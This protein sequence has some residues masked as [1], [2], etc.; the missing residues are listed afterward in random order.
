MLSDLRFA[1]RQFLK[2]P[3]F[4]VI[5]VLTLAL[6]IG[7]NVAIFSAIDAVLLHP[8][9]YPDPDR[10]V[11]VGE[12]LKHFNLSKIPASPPEIIDYRNMATTMTIGAVDNSGAYTLSGDGNPENIPGRRVTANIFSMLGVKPV[13]GGLF[14]EAQERYGQDRVAVISEGLWKRR[15][16]AN[17]SAIG[18]NIQINQ[19]NYQIVGVIRPILQF[20]GAGDIFTPVSFAPSD[21]AETKR[22]S[23]FVQVIGQLKPGV[24]I[25]QAHA[26]FSNIAARIQAQHPKNYLPSF[27]YSL[28]V[29][30]LAQQASGDLKQ[31]LLVLIAAVG[32]VMLIAC[33]NVSNL[34]LARAMARRKEISLR[35]ALGAARSRIVRQL[36]TESL[37]LATAA[38]AAG[39]AFAFAGL[40]L[41]AQ[42][43]P[44]D[45]IR[46]TQPDIN[47]WVLTFSILLSIAASVIFGLAPA[48]EISRTDLNDALKEGS[49]G[50]SGGRRFLRESMVALE[51]AASLVLLIGAGLLVRSF[52]RLEHADPGFRSDNVLTAQIILPVVQYK[53]PSQLGAFQKALMERVRSLPGVLQADLVN[54]MPFSNT[55]SASSFTIVD[56]PFNPNDPSPVVIETRVGPQYFEAMGI[57]LKRGRVFNPGDDEG[58]QKVAV[59]DETTAKKFFSNLDPIGLQISSPLPNVNCTVVGVVAAVKYRDLANPPEPI[60]YYAAAQMPPV[61]VNL[62]IKTAGDPLA[63]AAPLRHEVAALDP[64][65]P[66]SRTSTLTGRLEDSLARERFSIQLMAVFA[67]IAAILAAIGIYGVLAYLVDQRRRELGIRMALGARPGDVLGLVLRQGSIPIG[68]GL[69]AGIAAAFGLTWFLKSLL[70]EVSTTDPLI[71]ASVSMGLIAVALIAM[72]VPGWRATRIDPLE[73]LRQE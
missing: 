30:P 7:A 55:Y 32:V 21:L 2:T 70:Y 1:L 46:G 35:A 65:L 11:V 20:L 38:G 3:G 43:G 5:A 18:R 17:P 57:H 59:I 29:D 39:L 31:P 37:L 58:T 49:R 40:R 27:G 26:E 24:S 33:A 12:N 36:L 48:L 8:L 41:Y 42:F 9:P 34:L 72:L 69:A 22:G 63:L 56:H 16:G 14:T 28:D 50:S 6:A 4:S 64:N 60:I 54:F 23:Q 10:L 51:V 68:A 62:V 52:V 73:A 47:A 67:G 44:H 13:A 53:Q 61:L 19:E 66:V 71:Y 45:L 15:F 25:Q